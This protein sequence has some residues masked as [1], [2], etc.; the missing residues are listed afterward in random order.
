MKGGPAVSQFPPPQPPQVRPVAPLTLDYATSPLPRVDLR[1]IAI[2]QRA[3]ICCIL[4]YIVV[5]ASGLV[6]PDVHALRL[7]QA[8]LEVILV[9]AGVVF[10]FMLS[11]SVYRDPAAGIVGGILMLFPLIGLFILVVINVDAIKILRRHGVRV[12]LLGA[13]LRQIPSPG[14]VPTR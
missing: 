10:A 8:V 4:A 3:V 6:L 13:S 14:Q 1:T 9:I 2:R 12:G 7:T 11:L 5:A